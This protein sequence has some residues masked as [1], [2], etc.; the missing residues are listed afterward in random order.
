MEDVVKHI[1]KETNFKGAFKGLPIV[2]NFGSGNIIS[3]KK[4]AEIWWKKFNAK[5][6]I[7]FGRVK[8]RKNELMRYVPKV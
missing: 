3:L 6:K 8:Y 7:Y 4:F 1:I 2:T 5:G